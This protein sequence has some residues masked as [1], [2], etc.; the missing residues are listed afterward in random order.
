MKVTR[1]LASILL[2]GA[3]ASTSFAQGSVSIN[4]T[5]CT[6][7]IDIA[8]PGGAKVTALLSVLGMSTPNKAYQWVVTAGSPGGLKD[9]WRFDAAGCQGSSQIL[10][11]HNIAKVCAPLMGTAGPSL[12]ITDWSYDS[13]TGK[14]KATLAN[15]YPN[16]AVYSTGTT[17]AATTRYLLGG[18]VFDETYSVAGPGDPPNTCGGIEAPV[19]FH[20]TSASWLDLNSTESNWTVANEWITSN[21]PNNNSRC[22]GAT[23]AAAKTWGQVKS[24]YRN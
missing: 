6:G 19:C 9:A 13:G 15:S 4:W 12:Q 2:L 11:T 10:V 23:P 21:D 20:I 5:S 18:I 17:P 8:N 1:F 7:P 24:Q 16:G 22:P 3:T 14:A